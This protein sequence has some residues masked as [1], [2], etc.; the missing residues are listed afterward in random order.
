MVYGRQD[1]SYVDE[2]VVEGMAPSH[3]WNIKFLPPVDPYSI[4]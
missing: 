4:Y 1:K 2:V 3:K